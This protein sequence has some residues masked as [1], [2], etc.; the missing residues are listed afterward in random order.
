MRRGVAAVGPAT[1][2]QTWERYAVLAEWSSWSPPIRRVE[3]SGARLTAGLTGVVHGPPGVVIPFVV[4][5]VDEVAHTWSWHVHVGPLR[6][7]LEHEVLA[8]ST[9][10][11]ATTLVV[12]GPLPVALLYPEAARI[13]LSRLVAR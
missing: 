2:E 13:A 7:D 6:V 11:S 8:T 1:V 10:G 12:D 3:A 4:D 5:A 9:G